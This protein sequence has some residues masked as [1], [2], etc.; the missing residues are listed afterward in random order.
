[1]CSI[2]RLVTPSRTAR[3]WSVIALLC[4]AQFTLALDFSLLIAALSVLGEDPGFALSGLRWVDTAFA[5][6]SG[7]A[8]CSS[9]APPTP[10]ARGADGTGRGERTAAAVPVPA[11]GLLRCGPGA[12]G[13]RG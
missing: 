1:V 4:G 12:G 9:D 2:N 13:D 10:D 3:Q 6:P 5:L 7:A 8:C 11:P